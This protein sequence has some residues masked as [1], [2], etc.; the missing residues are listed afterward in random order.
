MIRLALLARF[1]MWFG[2]ADYHIVLRL[3]LEF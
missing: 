3:I 1:G 2:I